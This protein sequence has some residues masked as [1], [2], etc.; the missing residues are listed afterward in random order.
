MATTISS[1]CLKCGTIRKSGEASCCGH[2]GAWSK[3]CGSAG[4]SK[5]GHTWYEGIQACKTRSQ[6]KT[7]IGQQANTAQHESMDSSDGANKTNS[8]SVITAV[9]PFASMSLNM[10]TPMTVTTTIFA[11]THM[12]ANA[13]TTMPNRMPIDTPMPISPRAHTSSSTPITTQGWGIFCG[14]AG[15][16]FVAVIDL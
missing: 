16:L 11:P 12:P 13:S 4:N 8:A 3:N 5:F 14:I 2:G 7:V 9:K 1:E 6:S 15:L 10:S